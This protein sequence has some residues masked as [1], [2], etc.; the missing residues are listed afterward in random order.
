MATAAEQDVLWVLL[1]DAPGR[2]MCA[3]GRVVAP[4]IVDVV[5]LEKEDVADFAPF[6]RHR[7]LVPGVHIAHRL[8]GH[9]V[10]AALGFGVEDALT[11]FHCRSQRFFDEGVTTLL[12]RHHRLVGMQVVRPGHDDYVGL[13]LAQELGV[14]D[15]EGGL[16][17]QA[18]HSIEHR[19]L[20]VDHTCDL[21]ASVGRGHL[22]HTASGAATSADQEFV[23]AHFAAVLT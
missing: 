1:V 8:V 15:T 5:A 12:Q 16:W 9:D 10:C 6:G 18:L 2:V 23:L 22:R 20:R 4:H 21:A 7:H 19:L 14:V 3:F 17:V 13:R 11:V